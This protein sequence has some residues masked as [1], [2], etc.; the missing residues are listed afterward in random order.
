MPRRAGVEHKGR[1]EGAALPEQD[2][3]MV[4]VADLT[5]NPRFEDSVSR[6]AM[7]EDRA[8]NQTARRNRLF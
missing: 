5:R 8:K 4:K 3:R 2:D 6:R 1:Y 7:R